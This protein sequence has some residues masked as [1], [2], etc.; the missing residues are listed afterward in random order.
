L[1]SAIVLEDVHKRYRVYRHKSRSLKDV[2]LRRHL[3]IWEDRWALRGVSLEVPAGGAF[4]LIGAN[5]AGKSTMLKLIARVLTPDTGRVV[6]VG[7]VGSLI[8]LG[9]GFHPDSTGRENVYLNASLLGLSRGD[10]RRRFD[11]I[12]EFAG[13]AEHI[14]APLR[15]YSSGMVVR[16]GF[17]VAAHIDAEILLLDEILAVGDE[18]FQRRCLDYVRSF[19]EAGGTIVFVSHSMDSVRQICDMAAWIE[20][21]QLR[22]CDTTKAVVQLYIDKVSSSWEASREAPGAGESDLEITSVEL[23]GS[24]GAARELYRTGDELVIDI[25]YRMRRHV[26]APVFGVAVHRS[27]GLY[28]FGTNTEVDR[29]PTRGLLDEGVVAVRY[30]SLA[31]MSGAYRVTVAAFSQ[32]GMVPLDF[33]DQ[34]YTFRVEA[35][36]DAHGVIHMP[37]EWDVSAA[38]PGRSV[39]TS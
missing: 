5:G 16:L 35:G 19:R 8:E 7:R 3:G 33:H 9:A 10:I 4:G 11:A 14:D 20:N 32:P 38:V 23:R 24:D 27:D 36:D 17:A 22:A 15:T 6:T 1:A 31:L 26:P 39:M 12:V 21:G 29:L 2:A 37:H 28:V 13:L 34:R 30:P 25:G 18:S